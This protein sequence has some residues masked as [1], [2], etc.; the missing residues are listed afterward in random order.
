MS[1]K[2]LHQMIEDNAQEVDILERIKTTKDINKKDKNGNTPLHCLLNNYKIEIKI[3][4]VQALV[5]AGAN[6]NVTNEI[7][8]TPLQLACYKGE[9]DK[10]EIVQTLLKAGAD[11]KAVSISGDSALHYAVKNAR[12]HAESRE[13]DI[14]H[15]LIEAG[16][17]VNARNNRGATPIFD[18]RVKDIRTLVAAGANVNATDNDGNTPLHEACME[19]DSVRISA[20]LAEG[21][22]SEIENNA[23]EKPAIKR[24]GI[25]TQSMSIH[26]LIDDGVPVQDIIAAI[27]AGADVNEKKD[28]YTPLQQVVMKE[29]GSELVQ[30]LIDA[31]ADVNAYAT[32]DDLTDEDREGI[33]EG[34][35][36]EYD[37]Y[38]GAERTALAYATMNNQLDV[39]QTLLDAG[40]DVNLIFGTSGC[41]LFSAISFAET[42]EALELLI[43]NGARVNI[44]YGEDE[45]ESLLYQKIHYGNMSP[46]CIL[47]LLRAGAVASGHRYSDDMFDVYLSRHPE[48][49]D[50]NLFRQLWEKNKEERMDEVKEEYERNRRRNMDDDWE[51]NDDRED[52]DD[53]SFDNYS[54]DETED[55]DE[56]NDED[57]EEDEEDEEEEEEEAQSLYD[58]IEND[59]SVEEIKEAI[60]NGADVNEKKFHGQTPLHIAA[61]GSW[62]ADIV[63]ALVEA[64]ADVN[65]RDDDGFTPLHLAALNS[66]SDDESDE[67]VKALIESGA[68]V[69]AKTNDWCQD[70]D[71]PLHLALGNTDDYALGSLAVIRT[72]IEAGADVN[73]RNG[74]GYTPLRHL[75]FMEVGWE[76]GD[77]EIIEPYFALLRQAGAEL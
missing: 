67:G 66:V 77:H 64:G 45:P 17:D 1:K 8:Q 34:E 30:A 60:A 53:W 56:E 40:A 52:D 36:E 15:A 46:E 23:G 18:C 69:N 11:A 14:Y 74:H 50:P 61:Q 43:Q 48:I 73:A 47:T 28:Y 26:E 51:D 54:D 16:A 49:A 76:D 19:K 12:Y 9:A 7:E 38:D 42:K 58:L 6:V 31:G 20:L 21:A 24:W 22:D 44:E 3:K 33:E 57:D 59:A 2:T 72:L 4:M 37:V 29:M 39:M 65:A 55:E 13:D 70:Q 5:A 75:E 10:L 63:R 41:D 68:D 71:T 27:A 62:R 35:C 32:K 25:D